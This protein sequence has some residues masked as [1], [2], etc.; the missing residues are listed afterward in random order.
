MSAGRGRQMVLD[1]PHRTARGREDFLVTASNRAAVGMID[2]YPEWPSYAMVIAGPA[3]SG[4]THLLEVWREASG[5][6]LTAASGVTEAAVPGL[7]AT[8][9]LA[10]DEARGDGLDERG[11]FHLL[12]Y[13]RQTGGHVLVAAATPP[14]SW[15]IRIPDLASRLKALPV[16]ELGPP[17]DELL[18]GVLIKLFGDRQLAVDA[19]VISYLL[20]RMPRSLEAARALVAAIDRQALED[21]AEITRAFVGRI[22]QG[23]EAPELFASDD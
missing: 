10:I 20:V 16:A 13:A 22:L 21:K 18:R 8:G 12:N 17:D 9:A 19:G 3:G 23:F 6:A 14:V 15:V 5:A 1:L 4:K 2:R 7:M 11:L